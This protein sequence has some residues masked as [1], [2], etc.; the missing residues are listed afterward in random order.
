MAPSEEFEREKAILETYRKAIDVQ[1]HFNDLGM[2]LRSFAISMILADLGAAAYSLT[3]RTPNGFVTLG[4]HDVHL[5]V[6]IL[7]FGF[8]FWT[9]FCLVDLLWLWPLLR[10]SV[11]FNR[12]LEKTEKERGAWTSKVLGLTGLITEYSRGHK[13]FGFAFEVTA[14]K[15]IGLY[16]YGPMFL[17]FLLTIYFLWGHVKP[18]APAQ[19]PAP[20]ALVK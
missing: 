5:S 8:M 3:T 4:S 7:A 6:L 15:K 17:T 11:D 1:M 9:S 10:A 13:L 14:R 2:R 19:A 20:P 18:L 12:N 16:F